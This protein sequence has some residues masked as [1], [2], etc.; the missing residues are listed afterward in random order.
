[1][2]VTEIKKKR[3][4]YFLLTRVS[5][6]IVYHYVNFRNEC[7]DFNKPYYEMSKKKEYDDICFSRV[8]IDKLADIGNIYDIEIGKTPIVLFF[9]DGKIVKKMEGNRPE[10]LEDYVTDFSHL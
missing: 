1:M 2:P 10:L 7:I 9:K 3:D 8:D 6:V 5:K 4:L